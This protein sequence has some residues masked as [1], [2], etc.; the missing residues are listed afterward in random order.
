[1]RQEGGRQVTRTLS[2]E[3]AERMRP[4]LAADRRMK[5]LVHELE[6]LTVREFAD[7]PRT[8]VPALGSSRRKAGT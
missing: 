3:E 1:M 2:P 5:E 6:Q 7:Q 4:L 8:K